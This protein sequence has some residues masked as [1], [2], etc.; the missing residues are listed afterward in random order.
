MMRKNFNIKPISKD[1]AN[2]LQH[3]IDNKTKPL[4]ALG[5]LEALALH[6]GCLQNTLS[7]TLKKPTIVVFAGDHGMTA[8]G[9]SPYPQAVTYQRFTIFSRAVKEYETTHFYNTVGRFWFVSL[10]YQPE[11]FGKLVSI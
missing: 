10:H 4:G 3:K 11:N 7:P 6:I 2:E 1:K 8:E 5:R 9:V